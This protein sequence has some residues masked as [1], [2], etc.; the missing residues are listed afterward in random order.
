MNSQNQRKPEV[1]YRKMTHNNKDLSS[2]STSR[3]EIMHELS[4]N[5]TRN[6][7]NGMYQSW[8]YMPLL[9]SWLRF[10]N[11]LDDERICCTKN[12]TNGICKRAKCVLV[13]QQHCTYCIVV[14]K[15]V[16]YTSLQ[17]LLVLNSTSLPERTHGRP[18]HAGTPGQPYWRIDSQPHTSSWR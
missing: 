16:S 8:S 7:P 9:V 5:S 18:H 12:K 4:S 15:I 3:I 13:A 11:T 17:Q 10:T 14:K 1:Q 2:N 6:L